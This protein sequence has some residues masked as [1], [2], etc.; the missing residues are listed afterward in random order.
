M[1]FGETPQILIDDATEGDSLADVKPDALN[2]GG[3]GAGGMGGVTT[4]ATGGGGAGAATGTG[5]GGGDPTSGGG[6]ASSGGDG[7]DDG[8]CGC[9]IVGHGSGRDGT[10]LLVLLGLVLWLRQPARR[11]RASTSACSSSKS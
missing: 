6:G 3:G 9:V 8:G 1:D 2:A 4:G 10:A 11:S 7:D 5:G